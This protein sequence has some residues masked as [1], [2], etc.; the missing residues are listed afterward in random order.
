MFIIEEIELNG[1]L[2]DVHLIAC[3]PGG[4]TTTVLQEVNSHTA[5]LPGTTLLII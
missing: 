2:Y 4:N 5:L 1:T 3:T